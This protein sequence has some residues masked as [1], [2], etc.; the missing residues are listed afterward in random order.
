MIY[1]KQPI[2]ETTNWFK[3]PSKQ[4]LERSRSKLVAM[5]WKSEMT[6]QPRCSAFYIT[7][8]AQVCPA[9]EVPDWAKQELKKWEA[10]L[11]R[12]KTF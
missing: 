8:E 1:C 5:A 7:L 11:A 3:M 12:T 6:A 2:G 4:S 9:S 10:G